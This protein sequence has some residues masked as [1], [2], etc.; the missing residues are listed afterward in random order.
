MIATAAVSAA[1][2]LRRAR[3]AAG[4]TQV[5]LASRAGVTQSVISAYESSRREPALSTLQ[6]LLEATG[7]R[8]P[9]QLEQV[10]DAAPRSLPRVGLGAALRRQR[11]QLRR[12]VAA[13]GG[14]R[15]WVFGSAARGDDRPDSD[16]DLLVEL[17]DD[18]SLIDLG[19]LSEELEAVLGTHVD[20]VPERGVKPSVRA[21]ISPDLVRL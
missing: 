16:V 19:R 20:V 21:R 4:M 7:H 5:Q 17:P 3:L 9:L 1:E 14:G 8:L 2:L 12:I 15:V 11:R 18:V 6:R 10:D 13:H